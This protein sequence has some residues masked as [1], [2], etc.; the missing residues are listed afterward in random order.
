[1]RSSIRA[2][3]RLPKETFQ[4][5]PQEEVLVSLGHRGR[6]NQ[7]RTDQRDPDGV[8]SHGW[9]KLPSDHAR[10]DGRVIMPKG[11][12]SRRGDELNLGLTEPHFLD[13]LR[14]SS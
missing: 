1:M 13:R 11:D 5:L 3:I 7:G 6:S 12:A 8:H 9:V 2:C 10:A 4:N 14:F